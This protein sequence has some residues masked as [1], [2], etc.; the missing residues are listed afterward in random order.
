MPIIVLINLPLYNW[1]SGGSKESA[2]AQAKIVDRYN[3]SRFVTGISVLHLFQISKE[4][5]Y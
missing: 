3:I 4:D 5:R 1:I 2:K